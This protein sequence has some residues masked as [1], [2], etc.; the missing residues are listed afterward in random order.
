MKEIEDLEAK[1]CS[2]FANDGYRCVPFQACKDGEVVTNG[3]GYDFE[4]WFQPTQ[5]SQY[6]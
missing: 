1:K 6:C 4:I 3:A 5:I 2:E